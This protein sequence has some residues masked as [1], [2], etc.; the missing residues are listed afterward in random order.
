MN[1][2]SVGLIRWTCGW[3]CTYSLLVGGDVGDER[4]WS[5]VREHR[6]SIKKGQA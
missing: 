2:P 4:G 3:H 5:Q 1:A 6:L